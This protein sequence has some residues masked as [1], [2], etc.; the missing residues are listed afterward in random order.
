[1]RHINLN[2]LSLIITT[3]ILN[4]N[5]G[6]SD[7]PDVLLIT[8]GHD[9]DKAEFFS[10]FLSNNRISVDTVTQPLGNLVIE[11]NN[12]EDWDAIV[13][14]DMWQN[15]TETQKEAYLRLL[16]NGTGMIF[17]HH[18]LVSYQDWD[19]FKCIRGGKYLEKGYVSDSTELS[20]Y[21]HDLDLKV[22]VIDPEHPVT[23]G[24]K[25]FKI[26]DEGYYNIEILPEVTP[27]LQTSHPSCAKYIAWTKEYRNS[28]IVYIMLG[29]DRQAYNNP[30]F[31]Q[32]LNNSIKWVSQ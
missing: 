18:S 11:N 26:H 17:L 19:E 3:L 2:L 30:S 1:M 6:C 20:G 24:I 14:Y 15:I 28:R 27:L 32:L 9:F 5:Y 31:R 10:L 12:S 13:F 4:L 29:H 16:E 7:K 8:G 23:N 21:Q 22:T 25:D